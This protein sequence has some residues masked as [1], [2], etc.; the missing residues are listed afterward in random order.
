VWQ[1]LEPVFRAGESFPTTRPSQ[2][3]R[4]Q[5]IGSRLGRHSL[6]EAR[7]LGHRAMQFNCWQANGFQIVF[8][9]VGTLPGA[10]RHRQRGFVAVIVMFRTLA[11][12]PD[13]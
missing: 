6:R 5:G 4:R 7:R 3:S 12:A 8:Q 13:P 11:E 9:I 10:F 1:L 2:K